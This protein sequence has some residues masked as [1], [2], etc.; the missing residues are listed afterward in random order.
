MPINL[1]STYINNFIKMKN[2]SIV[3]KS[4]HI[5]SILVLILFSDNILAQN[6]PATDGGSPCYNCAPAGWVDGGGTPDVSN[7]VIA[8]ATGSG[9]GGGA[10]WD[11]PSNGDVLPNPFNSHADW[12]SLRDING[13]EET[14]S[15]TITN[16][17]V[18]QDYQVIIYWFAPVSNNDGDD[19]GTGDYYAGTYIEDFD[20]QVN[21]L[22]R[23]TITVSVAEQDQW[24]T[25]QAPFTATNTTASFAFFPG[26]DS[27][28]RGGGS[29]IVY[30]TVQLSV[31]VDAINRVPV[32][33]NNSDTTPFNT[34][35]TF[36]VTSTD[37]D[38]DGNIDVA[39]V[40]LDPTTAGIQN[41]ATTADGTWTV[42]ALGNVT[43]T[44]NNGFTGLTT[45]DYT[46]NDDYT[47]DGN[48]VAA[49]SNIA[50][51]TVTV[52]DGPDLS[53]TKTI[54][55]ATPVSGET[56]IFTLVL[57][58]TGSTSTT[59]VQ[60]ED[61]LPSGL[62][63]DSGNSTIPAGTSYDNVSGIWDLSTLTINNGD[64]FTLLIAAT[65][66]PNCGEITNTA[67]IISSNSGDLDSTTNNGN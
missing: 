13:T 51:L 65:V 2:A 17:V 38:A 15:T 46:V 60:V 63:Y 39:T 42:D 30:E 43:F 48:L 5:F 62:V 52:L 11:F 47:L 66:T 8:A 10:S 19:G 12:I 64:T 50:T 25:Y 36:N 21:G 18:G 3:T 40:D 32:A 31:T 35:T 20:Y 55:N 53:L 28:P 33:D 54:D 34:A 1:L 44:P 14:V 45:L 4:K 59:G 29:R 27:T 61:I 67:E 56:I 41:T 22:P 7:T 24:N 57:T 26:N 6:I 16:L 37:T 23:E 58:N 49:T 9:G